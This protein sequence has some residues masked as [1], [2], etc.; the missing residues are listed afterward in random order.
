MK[1]NV[2][3]NYLIT[4]K[5]LFK[6][7]EGLMLQLLKL[8]VNAAKRQPKTIDIFPILIYHISQLVID[9]LIADRAASETPGYSVDRIPHR[10]PPLRDA[11]NDVEEQ[12]RQ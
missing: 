3:L 10:S 5:Y 9:S 1:C 4:V 8:L 11:L 2:K 12:G 6:K 7:L